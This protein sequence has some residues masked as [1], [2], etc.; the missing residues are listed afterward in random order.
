MSNI[1]ASA[2]IPGNT[3]GGKRWQILL[4]QRGFVGTI[5][6]Q[7]VANDGASA[8]IFGGTLRAKSCTYCCVSEDF[9]RHFGGKRGNYSCISED[10][11][12]PQGRQNVVNIVALLRI[13]GTLCGQNV[14]NIVASARISGDTLRAKRGKYCCVRE[15]RISRDTLR[16]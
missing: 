14:A 13:S 5:C 11:W 7:R 4:R 9:W 10:F 16:A 3:F 2:K 12:D 6:G 8:R 1:G 15:A